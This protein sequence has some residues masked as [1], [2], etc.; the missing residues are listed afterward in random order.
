MNTKI[1]PQVLAE[2]KQKKRNTE[3]HFKKIPG[4]VDFRELSWSAKN[5]T[6]IP[7]DIDSSLLAQQD[8]HSLDT[9]L[10][11]ALK[12]DRGNGIETFETFLKLIKKSP[13]LDLKKLLIIQNKDNKTVF[14]LIIENH[15]YSDKATEWKDKKISEFL[16]L[17]IPLN[18]QI[19]R[20]GNYTE[21]PKTLK[22]YMFKNLNNFKQI[23][24]LM[25]EKLKQNMLENH[26]RKLLQ[27]AMLKEDDE[28]AILKYLMEDSGLNNFSELDDM[29]D[30]LLNNAIT[31]M[32]T[33]AVSYLRDKG[34]QLY[35]TDQHS[36]L[37]TA[38]FKQDLD[39][40]IT[41]LHKQKVDVFNYNVMSKKDKNIF[42]DAIY[43][44][45]VKCCKKIFDLADD[46]QKEE[47]TSGQN[48]KG[49]T[50]LHLAL[51]DGEFQIAE[52]LIE[53]NA[54]LTSENNEGK[55]PLDLIQ[56]V[57]I[58]YTGKSF[59][60]FLNKLIKIHNPALS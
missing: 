31:E 48:H 25:P 32:R 56:E 24:D 14:D 19:F 34:A 4:G 8:I 43:F 57:E 16:K 47:I 20:D 15:F 39:W 3:E 2:I 42:R 52:F 28:L 1:T 27:N 44:G 60:N 30:S 36:T 17:D 6:P 18:D 50:A 10:H 33:E 22:V 45:A 46:K 59:L 41:E 23:L 7:K 26:S 49:N 29:G 38:A 37:F 5:G 58:E 9:P 54:D 13:N 55:T 51:I 21:I 53:H 12:G 11:T 40:V 35:T